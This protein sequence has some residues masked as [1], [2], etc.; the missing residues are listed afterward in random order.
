MPFDEVR[1]T[2]HILG[3]WRV[4]LAT[5]SVVAMAL[6]PTT[7]IWHA[8]GAYGLAYLAYGLIM[9]FLLRGGGQPRPWLAAIVH[10]A[11]V[12]WWVGI[13]ALTAG[14]LGCL[15]LLLFLLL[16]AGYRWGARETLITAAVG[17]AGLMVFGSR[18]D[19]LE[20]TVWL[21]SLPMRAGYLLFTASLVGVIADDQRRLRREAS[22]TARILAGAHSGTR[23]KETLKTVF[24]CILH[25]FAARE[26]LL[27]L[28][29]TQGQH[30]YLW[31]AGALDCDDAT[32]PL[33]ELDSSRERTYLFD[34]P[35][36][37]WNMRRRSRRGGRPP[38]DCIAVDGEGHRLRGP[39]RALPEDVLRGHLFRKALAIS[40]TSEQWSGRLFVI[41]P[42]RDRPVVAQLRFLQ[43]LIRQVSPALQNIHLVRTL[44]S[45]AGA[46]ERA[47]VARELHDGVIQSLIGLEMKVDLVRRRAGQS[48]QAAGELAEIESQLHQEVI[49]L[50]ELIGQMRPPNLKPQQLL[51]FL[52]EC[53]ERF[54]RETGISAS[55][56]SDLDEV[57][58]PARTCREVARIVQ[59]GLVNA[60]KHSHAK[61]VVV[62]FGRDNGHWRVSIDDDGRGF[63][64]T[65]R[66]GPSE[67][68]ATRRGP[69]VIKERVRSMGGAL[70]IE[71]FPDHGAR[72][73]ITLPSKPHG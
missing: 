15:A 21:G 68:D 19:S 8:A 48:P 63:G 54:Q 65:G 29:E 59:E 26:A 33:S 6:D 34:F 28:R 57:R 7:S 31:E 23:F 47:R 13:A 24:D 14:S 53:V 32:G 17:L 5:C 62:R 52:A 46:A 25:H 67:L 66:L 37:A 12:A 20:A 71:S 4:C 64:F 35:A 22:T 55:F 70:T 39:S 43:A 72:L 51:D 60:R 50:R 40:F 44:R 10:G 27:V 30:A 38:F 9:L 58:L 41:D 11:D 61:N 69:V 45:R 1:H 2:E 42:G 36:A 16:A 18:Q 49:N 3:W 56:V 73:E